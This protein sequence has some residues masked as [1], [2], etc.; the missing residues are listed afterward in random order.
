MKEQQFVSHNK[1]ALKGAEK[2]DDKYRQELVREKQHLNE[3]K[4]EVRNSHFKFGQDIT[5][6]LSTAKEFGPHELTS[7]DVVARLKHMKQRKDDNRKANFKMPYIRNM[8]TEQSTYRH[9]ISSQV[10]PSKL[11]SGKPDIMR[12]NPSL[13]IG[14]RLD[15][16]DYTSEFKS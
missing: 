10:E 6:Y 5:K 14:G 3:V 4:T 13:K 12:V 1:E 8:S 16:K 11:N 9:E 7:D 15:S 2:I